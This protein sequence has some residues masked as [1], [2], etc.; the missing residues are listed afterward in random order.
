MCGIAGKVWF[1]ADRPGDEGIV[2]HMCDAIRHRG[3]DDLGL[4]TDG[5]ACLGMRRLSIIDLAGGH[6]PI[7]NESGRVGVV[8]NGEIYNYR[9]LRE[10]L[11]ARGHVLR[12]HSDTEVLVHLYEDHGERLVEHLRGM[13]AFAIWDADQDVLLLGRD[14]F[15]IKPLYV[16]LHHDRL[17]FASELKALVA[18]GESDRTLDRDALDLY[19]QLGYIP[20]PYTPFT[21]V[22]KLPPAHTLSWRRGEA[23][24]MRRY[25]NLP[26]STE[27][28]TGD[29]LEQVRAAFD[30]SVA[31]HLV[32][33]VPIAAFLSGGIDSSAVVSSMAVL[34]YQSRAFTARYHGSGAAGTDEVPLAQALCNKW[35]VPLTVVD[36]EP[37]V[38]S[39]LGPICR[40]LDEPLS[41]ESALP[42]WLLSAAVA[43]SYKVVLAGTG[44]DEL[45][46][47]YRRHRALQLSTAWNRVPKV[48][49]TGAS[50]LANTLPEPKSGNLTV[51]RIK[52]FLR[53]GDES[54]AQR[55]AQ[56]VS[57][58]TAPDFTSLRPGGNSARHEA[59]FA[60]IATDGQGE[61]A[62]RT[63]LRI[64]YG[65]YLPDDILAVSDRIASAHSLEVRVPFVDHV[66]VEQLLRL[67]DRYR[68]RG[69]TQKWVLREAVRD[70]LTP[71]HFTAPKR[72]FVG[73]T[74]SG[75]V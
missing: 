11:L 53:A 4:W 60:S 6:Q 73:P 14:R 58:L 25:W 48:F 12:T 50:A 2:Q 38:E 62:L 3:P 32:A 75:L 21:D 57:R 17:A 68:I 59:L 70:R 8:M 40:A 29:V 44:G 55:Y 65:V 5:S 51:G 26:S 15:G 24:A 20:A 37:S 42:T 9:E 67:P 19:L 47:G 10:Q 18:A 69:G 7:F 74:A 54:T 49:R 27:E 64:D 1:A 46:G 34:G 13:F 36:V 45:F 71:A 63:A 23:P 61:S 30:D 39:L 43:E 16:A 66:L 22:R 28:P 72:G 33:D 41:D 35:G 31:A 52:R 56:F